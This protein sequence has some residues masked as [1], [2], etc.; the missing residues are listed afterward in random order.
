[1][2]EVVV[3]TQHMY[4]L[5]LEVKEAVT[6]LAHND[7]RDRIQLQDHEDRIRL[8]ES[9]EDQSRRITQMED[10]IKA[11]RDELESMK[12]KLWAIPSASA[13]I[14]GAAV[15]ITLINVF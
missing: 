12:K 1:M 7:E 11:I 2:S 10:D 14:A 4:D 6:T 8:I 3:T 13:V 9:E 5:L 15:V